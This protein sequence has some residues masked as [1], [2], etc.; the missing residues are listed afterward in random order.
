[1]KKKKKKKMNRP[2]AGTILLKRTAPPTDEDMS[3]S[4]DRRKQ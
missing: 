3:G 2:R 1:M 4:K